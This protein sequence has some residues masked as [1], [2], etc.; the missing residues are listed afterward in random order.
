MN[1]GTV[2]AVGLSRSGKP[3]VT[4]D[5]TIY[6]ASKVDL[7]TMRAGD[8]IEFDSNSSVYNGATV[9]FLNAWKLVEGAAKYAQASNV[10]G[11]PPPAISQTGWSESERLTISN[12]VAHAIGAG[13]IKEP[14]QIEKWVT[15]ARNAIREQSK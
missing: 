9:W 3:T 7:G 1:K 15:A 10:P 6:S 8:V 12:W 4:I 5:G 2:Q 14:E 13:V 11:T